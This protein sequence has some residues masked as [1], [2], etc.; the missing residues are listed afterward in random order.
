MLWSLELTQTRADLATL[1]VV[2]QSLYLELANRDPDEA[3]STVYGK[4]AL[5]LRLI[6]ETIGRER[7]DGF[8]RSYFN[9]H[10]FHSMT[11]ASFIAELNEVFPSVAEK[12]KLSDW[13][14]GPGLPAN[15]PIPQSTE[16]ANVVQAAETWVKTG[17]VSP[18]DSK[19]SSHERVAFIESLPRLSPGRMSELDAHFRFSESHNSEVLGSWL[20]KAAEEHYRAAYPAIERF[21]KI[22]GRRKFLRPIYEALAKTSEDLAFARQ[23][24]AEARP[25]YHP[26]SQG[27]IDGILN[28]KKK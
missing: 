12:V 25:T 8:L 20:R 22:Q 4:G 18:L 13:I 21:L 14:H 26:V 28:T 19:W 24:Y 10:A 9:A 6:E 5:L 16:I 1:P 27:T 3:P 15:C 7:W 11:T 17:D 2:D 23:I